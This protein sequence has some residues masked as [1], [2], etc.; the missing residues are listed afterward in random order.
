MRSRRQWFRT[1]SVAGR[2]A[3]CWS[4]SGPVCC[5]IFL[6]RPDALGVRALRGGVPRS[7]PRHHQLLDL[8]NGLGR[9][10]TLRT[11]PGAVHDGVAAIE[12][13]RVLEIVEP[14]AGRLV[15]AVG[16][17]A[18]GLQQDRRA[19][20]AVAAPPVARAARGAAEAQDAFP[21][22]VEPGALLRRMRPLAPGP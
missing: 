12:A 10:E 19:K 13:E 22:P 4:A 9:I 15:A 21:Q 7:A 6:R 5:G 20:I 14:L 2:F 1:R 3:G 18:I 8:G 11:G 16:D 17:P